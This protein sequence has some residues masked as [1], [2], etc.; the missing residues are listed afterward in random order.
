[1]ALG[2]C[3][4]VA[5][6]GPLLSAVGCASGHVLKTNRSYGRVLADMHVHA[7]INEWNR[8]SPLGVRYP[9]LAYAIEKSV[10]KTGMAWKD[11]FMA[12][13]DLVCVAHYNAFD[14]LLSMPTDPNPEAP[15][16]TFR[17]MD[18]LEEKL[19]GGAR[20]YAK[21]AKNRNE[22]EDLL[23]VR[24]TDREYRVA[25]VHTLEG[26][27]A[28]GGSIAPLELFAKRGVAMICVT[29]FFYNGIA[30]AANPFPFFPDANSRWPNLGLSEF[31]GEVINEMERL[32]IL[33]DITHATSTSVADILSIASRP[34]V[35]S[36]ASARTLGDHPYSLYDEHI[37]QIARDGGIIS[38]II[39]PYILSNFATLHNARTEGT[40][41]EVVRTIRYIVKL[42]GT[43]KQV[44]I[45]SDFAG[46]ITGPKDM[47]R[48]GQIGRLRSLLLREFG[49]RQMVEDIMANNVIR[50]LKTHW[51]SG[52]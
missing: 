47:S 38:V 46:Y 41:R 2:A 16:N 25:V 10:N 9:A 19:Q 33:I 24:K 43:H 20:Q 4:S 37:Q 14:E 30:T 42:C 28:L 18:K 17:M 12:G 1:M 35:A 13:I 7:E 34:L 39:Y 45:G 27:H 50:F 48:L 23:S 26:G 51:R 32:G 40:L 21:L 36:H 3:A 52:L 6:Y 11:C 22:L 8:S 5:G 31:G 15:A 29:H 49:N 44:G